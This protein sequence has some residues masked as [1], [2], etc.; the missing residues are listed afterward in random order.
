MPDTG[1]LMLGALGLLWLARGQNGIGNGEG[2]MLTAIAQ[3]FGSVTAAELETMTPRQI[4]EIFGGTAEGKTALA[5]LLEADVES[6]GMSSGG[7][8]TVNKPL[9]VSEAAG[10]F[11]TN[12]AP[13][14]TAIAVDTT[15]G[16]PEVAAKV[17]PT[18]K[19][20]VGTLS[21][22]FVA[23]GPTVSEISGNA[24]RQV[25]LLSPVESV[26]MTSNSPS[27]AFVD[28]TTG[29]GGAPV[30]L[31]EDTLIEVLPP[32]PGKPRVFTITGNDEST[33]VTTGINR[34]EESYFT[35]P[36]VLLE[37]VNQGYFDIQTPGEP[38]VVAQEPIREPIQ[39]TFVSPRDF[40][41]NLG[42]LALTMTE[43]QIESLYAETY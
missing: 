7:S 11:F 21:A 15:T 9:I 23:Q 10:E 43:R 14:S 17:A 38:I 16:V 24:I 28:I 30:L 4:E 40:R 32:A 22:L 20:I 13:T 31:E 5:Q 19:E 39:P 34:W 36:G 33:V 8:A 26:L 18:E 27:V 35:T 29:G 37:A 12:G 1:M 3:E 41:A 25:G 42:D 2:G 6:S